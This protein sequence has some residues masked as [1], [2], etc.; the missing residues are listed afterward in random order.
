[1]KRRMR[2]AAILIAAIGAAQDQPY[3]IQRPT[4]PI[5]LRSYAPQNVPPIRMTNSERL[6][7]LIRAGNLYLSLQDALALAIENNLNLE[8]N[9]YGPL[10]ADSSLERARAG[11]PIRGV[12]SASQQVSAVNSG[13]GVNGVAAAA[14]V[15]GGGG[16]GG[17]GGATGGAAIQ[18]V[19]AVT[20]ILDPNMQ[21]TTTFSHLTQPQANT[22]LSQTSSLVQSLHNYN[23]VVQ[24]GLISGGVVQY[25][26]F[27]GYLKENAPDLLNP[28]LGSH[29]DLTL[30]HDLL[31]N[32]GVKLN[33]RGIRIAQI[34]ISG[35]REV[36]RSQLFDLTV[37]VQNL[38]WDLVSARDQLKVRERAL[39]VTSKFV[40]DTKYEIGVGAIPAVEIS[41]A[42]AE[43]AS[44]RQDLA[45][46]QVA[47]RQR[48]DLL[49]EAISHTADPLLEAAEIVPLDRIEVPDTEELPPLR[50]LLKTA[51]AK[52][53]DV[54]VAKLRDQTSEIN[55]SGTENPLLPSLQVLLQTFNRGLSGEPGT[56]G[57]NPFFVGG[58]GNALGQIFRRNFPNNQASIS[59]SAPFNNRTSQGDYGIDQL[60]FRQAQLSSQRDQNQ[61]LVDVSSQMNALRQ[62]RS[63]YATAKSGRLLNEQLL[64]VEQRRAAGLNT[65]TIVMTDQ[66]ALL[67]AQLSEL[68][69]LA[70]YA[71]ARVGLDQVLGLTLEKNGIDLDEGMA[72]KVSRESHPPDILPQQPAQAG[73]N[74]AK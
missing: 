46:A 56:R 33:N 63:R 72:G 43:E 52:R 51:L 62:A 25:R 16:G 53:P 59:F 15:G 8:I 10:L 26:S 23:N 2:Y 22:I 32:F 45:I 64:E 57:T 55:L 44:R 49:K 68:N 60:Q 28:A 37:S 19:G 7:T 69:A 38:Y 61:I 73:A 71:R 65:M 31:Q 48:S 1:M 20:R 34:N 67:A 3:M 41:R 74:P 5:P 40:T 27:E 39:A 12:P 24:Q 50:D 66:R 13:V 42:E 70:T 18:Q 54:T 58:Y 21:S 35:A 47:L 29:M 6:H 36:F 17:G 30:R 11:G 9:R 14:G 4:L